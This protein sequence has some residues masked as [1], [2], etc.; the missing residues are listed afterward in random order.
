MPKSPSKRIHPF[1]CYDHRAS[2]KEMIEFQEL[3][4]A[5]FHYA[6]VPIA[7][8]SPSIVTASNLFSSDNQ[9]TLPTGGIQKSD[10]LLISQAKGSQILEGSSLPQRQRSISCEEISE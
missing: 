1:F 4:T 5:F 7:A 9:T 10:E 8:D 6:H 2:A 3:A